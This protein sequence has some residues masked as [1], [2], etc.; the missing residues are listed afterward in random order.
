MKLGIYI[1]LILLFS[2]CNFFEKKINRDDLLEQKRKELDKTQVDKYPIFPECESINEDI[3]IEKECF[4][5][6]LSSHISNYLLQQNIL[7]EQELNGSLTL[8]I[9]VTKSGEI[10]IKSFTIDPTIV[11]QI[12]NIK[13]LVSESLYTLP[14]IVPAYKKLSKTGD[15]IPVNTQFLIPINI[16]TVTVNE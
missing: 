2:S 15:H 1:G 12:P 3:E 7:L 14:E 10:I 4:I 16:I 11:E 6:T 8:V 13:A 9:E 5:K